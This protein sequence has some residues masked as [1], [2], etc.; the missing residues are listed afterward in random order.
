MNEN[1]WS[2]GHCARKKAPGGCQLHN[3]Q[4]GYPDCDRK[5]AAAP[6]RITVSEWVC[7]PREPTE[8][9]KTGGRIENSEY[10][11]LLA[12]SLYNDMLAAAPSP[13]PVPVNP[14]EI[15]ALRRD[16]ER[17]RAMWN[18]LIDYC[19]ECDQPEVFLQTWREGD[20]DVCRED[21]PDSP[22]ECYPDAALAANGEK[23]T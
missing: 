19:I 6:Q 15:E 1:D 22:P 10:G 17:E 20:F 11:R 8:R 5:R 4:C 23:G 9:M 13:A 16:A 3:L 21:W 7:V 14:A 18:A 12:E 2:Y